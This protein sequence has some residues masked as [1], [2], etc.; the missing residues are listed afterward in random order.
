M[1]RGIT[2]CSPWTGDWKQCTI[3]GYQTREKVFSC[4]KCHD[5][6]EEAKR[7]KSRG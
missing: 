7:L 3:C 2:G 6:E 5:N 4:P 1:L